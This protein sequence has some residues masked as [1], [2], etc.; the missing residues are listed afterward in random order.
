MYKGT[1][2]EAPSK[3]MPTNKDV[4]DCSNTAADCGYY[5]EVRTCST[6][7]DFYQGSKLC[8]RCMWIF[9]YCGER[10]R[11]IVIV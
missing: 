11:G 3:T 4:C 2:L 1:C 10:G 6:A 5:G 8:M 7:A 9:L